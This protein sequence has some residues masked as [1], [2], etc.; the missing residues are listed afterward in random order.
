M[1]LKLRKLRIHW[2]IEFRHKMTPICL[3][4]AHLFWLKSNRGAK[5]KV[6]SIKLSRKWQMV[7]FE[8]SDPS[9]SGDL[10][11]NCLLYKL[12]QGQS[13]TWDV[14]GLDI[15]KLVSQHQSWDV[16]WQ[17]GSNILLTLGENP[18]ESYTGS[19]LTESVRERWVWVSE[20][21]KTDFKKR[22]KR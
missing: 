20:S 16:T 7:N 10:A 18:N 12:N 6:S 22:N 21:V 1:A 9:V 5:T 17:D 14:S 3:R 19:R 2:F 13:K 4:L 11:C 15:S 8:P